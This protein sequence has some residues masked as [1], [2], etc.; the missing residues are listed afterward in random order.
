M[1]LNYCIHSQAWIISQHQNKTKQKKE[2]TNFFF[3]CL[4]WMTNY[5]RLQLIVDSCGGGGGGEWRRIEKKMV[6]IDSEIKNKKKKVEVSCWA[7]GCCYAK[8]LEIWNSDD[9][10]IKD[11]KEKKVP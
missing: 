10:M 11:G 2:G 4:Y 6:E 9:L 3:H 5:W 7:A 1:K 8:Q